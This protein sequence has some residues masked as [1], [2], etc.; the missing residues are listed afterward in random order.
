MEDIFGDQEQEIEDIKET[1]SD[2]EKV[3]ENLDADELEKV[4]N[5]KKKRKARKKKINIEP[6]EEINHLEAR[7]D[8]SEEELS[9][10]DIAEAMSIQNTLKT[11]I[12]E[13]ANISQGTGVKH[14]LPSGIQLLDTIAGGGFACGTLS[15]IAGNPGTFKSAL[16]AQIIGNNQRKYKGKCL[17]LYLDSEFAMT[18]NR[19]RQMGV[20]NPEQPLGCRTIEDVFKTIET[21]AVWK[22]SKEILD[23]PSIIGVDSLANLRAA[24]ELAAKDNEIEK[25]VGVRARVMSHLLAKYIPKIED[26]NIG[27]IMINQLRDN[28]KIG[29]VN[30]AADL[31]WM[32]NKNIP[33]GTAL[34]YNT[35]Q[36]LMLAVKKDLFT[37]KDGQRINKWGFEG[38]I[39]TAR[40]VKNKLFMPNVSIELI[41]DFNKGIS[42]FWTNYHFLVTHN[43]IKS[44]SWC[45]F[46]SNPEFKWRTKECQE[47]YKNEPK[48]KELFDKETNDVIKTEIIDKYVY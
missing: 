47:K 7:M 15:M 41:V 44:A 30:A 14:V 11:F 22:D 2:I 3:V 29:P 10:A 4:E 46:V 34:K 17:P 25:Q 9:E 12:T 33:G 26:Y 27:L 16:L 21:L 5:T 18:T 8:Y 37:I 38:V 20:I 1:L 45:S 23:A 48:F 28:I 42:N 24:K 35:F 43:R 40:F 32:G 39:L 13:K 6:E 36:L 31:K 19:L